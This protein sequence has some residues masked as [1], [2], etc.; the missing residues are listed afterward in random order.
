MMTRAF[1]T[2]LLAAC[3]AVLSIAA[4]P[5]QPAASQQ[6]AAP[7]QQP[8][9]IRTRIASDSGVTPRYAVPEFVALTPNAAEVARTLGQVLWDDLNFER[10]F[11]MIQRDTA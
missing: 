4:E 1:T 3:V 5:R 8:S 7:A 10:E 9:D 11:Q 2:S 6:P